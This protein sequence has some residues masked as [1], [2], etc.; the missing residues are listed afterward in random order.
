MAEMLAGS[1]D[2]ALEALR[3]PVGHDLQGEHAVLETGKPKLTG[4]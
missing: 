1:L 2:Q 3:S 4:R